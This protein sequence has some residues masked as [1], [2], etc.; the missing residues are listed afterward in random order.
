MG[1]IAIENDT[2][3]ETRVHCV[4]TSHVT[5]FVVVYSAESELGGSAKLGARVESRRHRAKSRV[6]LRAGVA[7][8]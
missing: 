7:G 1:M 2:T 5:C 4:C 3:E 8:K 6:R